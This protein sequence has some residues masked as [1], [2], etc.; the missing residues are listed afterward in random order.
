MKNWQCLTTNEIS[1]TE[2]I[3]R[4]MAHGAKNDK[5]VKGHA[6]HAYYGVI[7]GAITFS[8]F[9]RAGAELLSIAEVRERFPLEGK[10]ETADLEPGTIEWLE[11]AKSIGATH[12]SSENYFV[13]VEAGWR[14]G[15]L[16][17][18]EFMWTHIEQVG[19]RNTDIYI[20][21]SPLEETKATNQ[22]PDWTTA[23]EGAIY[24]GFI[25]IGKSR[26]WANDQWYQYISADR[27]LF[28]A[29]GAYTMGELI[30]AAKKLDTNKWNGQ[31]FPPVGTVCE[32]HQFTEWVEC[33]I[34]NHLKDGENIDVIY[35]YDN[36]TKWEYSDRKEHF[37]PIKSDRDRW[38]DAAREA[39]EEQTSLGVND[40]QLGII[41]DAG[42][43][44]LPEQPQ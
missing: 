28:G 19:I 6:E 23:P 17:N 15:Y 24:Y 20:D 37:R 31:G 11:F 38:V 13:K 32:A 5:A 21:F 44:K 41:Y 9:L 39:M 35:T 30:I 18:S 43:A 40:F 10:K 14:I 16:C 25:G 1:G 26:V 36:G 7:D 4:A 12:I 33:V 3:E 34:E 29:P 22:E 2:I 27:F 42:L 8:A